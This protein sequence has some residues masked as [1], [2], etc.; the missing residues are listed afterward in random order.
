MPCPPPLA[1]PGEV[2][3]RLTRSGYGPDSGAAL[4]VYL[5]AC[6]RKM[7]QVVASGRGEQALVAGP[8]RHARRDCTDPASARYWTDELPASQPYRG[9]RS[10]ND[11]I[12]E[13]V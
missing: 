11:L 1:R 2:G 10:R 3:R 13:W 9:V 12:A 5:S 6:C 8:R 4:P 7:P